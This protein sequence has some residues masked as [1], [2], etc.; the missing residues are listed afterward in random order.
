MTDSSYLVSA[1]DDWIWKWE[2]NGWK[3]VTGEPVVNRK[4]LRLIQ[5][6]LIN[7]ENRGAS[8]KFWLVPREHNEWA[9]ALA[10]FGLGKQRRGTARR[11][12]FFI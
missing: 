7:L 5:K 11:Y 3:T 1:M 9:D 4:F 12:Y 2:T 10:N 6:R 8:I